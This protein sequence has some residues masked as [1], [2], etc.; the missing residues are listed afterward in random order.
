MGGGTDRAE[1]PILIQ[2][3]IASYRTVVHAKGNLIIK[4]LSL[5]LV[6]CARKKPHTHTD[7]GFAF[8]MIFQGRHC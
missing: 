6:K 8:E 4:I 5:M 1:H 2:Y 3:G 7:G